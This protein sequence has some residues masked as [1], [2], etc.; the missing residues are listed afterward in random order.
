VK[1]PKHETIVQ[2][3]ELLTK[4]T[5][6]EHTEELLTFEDIKIEQPIVIVPEAPKEEPVTV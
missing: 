6:K 2:I 4:V 5:M 3:H 1:K